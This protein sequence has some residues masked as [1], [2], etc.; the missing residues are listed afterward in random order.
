[1]AIGVRILSDNL[2]GLS[3]N[4]VYYPQSGGTIDLGTQVFP[5]S[6]ISNYYY[7]LYAC[8]VPTYD[9]TYTVTVPEP[10]PT[11]SLTSTVTP[12]ITLTPT[13][14]PTIT[15][16]KTTTP[17]ASITP[18]ITP[19]RNFE[20][21]EYYNLINSSDRGN[22]I[23]SYVN[24]DGYLLTGNILRPNSNLS[25]CSKKNTVVRTAGVNSLTVVDLGLCPTTPTPTPTPTVTP[26]VTSTP[27]VTPTNTPT[28]TQTPTQT[29]ASVILNIESYYS[30]GSIYAGY[31]V[32]AST[33]LNETITISF[34]DQ[35]ETSTPPY[36]ILNPVT[37]TIPLG[38]LTGFTQTVLLDAYLDATQISN[39]SGITVTQTGSTYTYA[40]TTGYTYNATPTPTPTSTQTP[41]PTPTNTQTPTNTPTVSLTPTN[42]ETPT[43]TPTPTPTLEL[44]LIDP[45]LVGFDE[46]LSVGTDEYLMFVDPSPSPTPTN[47]ET[48]TPTVTETPTNTPTPTNTETPTNTPT[49]TNTDTP[50][51][52]PTETPTPTNTETPTNT[53][54]NTVT[55][56]TTNT[57]TP[58]NTVTPTN[59]E[60]PTNTPTVTPTPNIV[61]SGLIMQLDAN[62]TD[63]YPGTGT[64]VFDLTG[65]YDN[66]LSGGA[67]FTTLNGVKCFDCS[68]GNES[69]QVNGTGPSLP[70]SGYTY[71]TWSRIIPSSSGWRSL[72]RTNN[73]LPILV[74]LGTDNLGLYDS[75]FRDSGYDV[76][77][78]EDVWTQYAVVGD[79]TS[80]IF[81]INGTQVGT[82][83][84]GAGGDIHVMWGNN[85]LAGQ[86]F[87]YLA[88]LYFY[89]RK[90]SFSEINQ[91]YNFL[92]PNFIE[93]TPT[94]TPTTTSSPTVTPTNTTTVT[95]TTTTTSTPTPTSVATSIFTVRVSEVGS[96]VVW[97]GSGSFNLSALSLAS[98]GNNGSA[99]SALAGIW[100]IGPTTPC[101]RYGGA[102]LTGYSTTFGNN[103]VVPTPI[104]SGS[105][106]GVTSGGVSGRVVIVP[107]GYVSNTVISGT[108]TY[109]GATIASMGLTPGTYT[110]AWGSGA[111]SSSIVMTIESSSVTPTPTTTQTPTPTSTPTL[112]PTN[113]PTT[114]TTPTPTSTPN[115]PVSSNLVLYYDPSNSSS[116]SGSGTTINDLSG[117]GL[118]GTMSNITF[119]SPYF[120][121]NGTSSQIRVPDN[122]LLEPGTGDWTIE[123]WVNQSV[124][125]GDVVLGKFNNSGR[126]ADVSYSVRTT[127][128]SYYGQIG[129]GV[130]V[131]DSTTHVGTIGTWYQIVYVWT[132]VAANTLQT[133]VNGVSIGSVSHGFSS[134]LN[135]GNPLYIGSYN[136]GEYSQWFDG[137]IG[138]TRLYNAALTSSQVLQNFNADKSKYGL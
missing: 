13:I 29:P 106:F 94:P 138:I 66:T 103:L 4:V 46:Y 135:S 35:I 108:A 24:C 25:L 102:S 55:P 8:Y 48:P 100:A 11:P 87:G 40:F 113:T 14:T 110:W 125:G 9:Y 37:I 114:T 54:T 56:T 112:T 15:P 71:V 19:T 49:P 80:S 81:Y 92:S 90:L 22:V 98:S 64:T 109:T 93:V 50:T 86:S 62:K 67:T 72:L 95:P 20:G 12:T 118:S 41:T 115:A 60:T 101:Q 78:I 119:T 44:Q 88:N 26:T 131:V 105:T 33:V 104:S 124:S 123:V 5:F 107:S 70:T 63:S 28:S 73:E 127:N 17:T 84:Y 51:N 7:G 96:D 6:Y 75:V 120:T 57:E 121:Y 111:N 39:F 137:K 76:T 45:I 59:T 85:L 69:I 18:T 43:N 58:T 126:A 77:P 79:S 82:V 99:F 122:I 133:F 136:G 61:L 89:D 97:S 2:S 117:N 32:T 36:E 3:T 116:Y 42:T 27:T 34:V 53:P 65:S 31:G 128:T 129:N 52:T 16:T 68:T 134:I 10:T 74:Q 1:M 132:N 47:T 91:M 38:E 30:P 130:G 23:Y 21:C 83:A